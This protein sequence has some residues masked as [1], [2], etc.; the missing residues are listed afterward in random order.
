MMSKSPDGPTGED[1]NP[2]RESALH[3]YRG[4]VFDCD[5][6]LLNSN[7]VKTRAF[8][9][10][11]R[12][13]GEA[14]ATTLVD[15]HT[16]HGGIS[17]YQKFD[18]FFRHIL[19]Y[20]QVP[21]QEMAKILSRFA[22]A[23]RAGMASCEEAPGL[24]DFLSLLPQGCPR[25][26]ISGGDQE[27]LRGIFKARGLDVYFDAILGSPVD[28]DTHLGNILTEGRIDLPAVFFGDAW[29]DFQVA[30]RHGLDFIFLSGWSELDAWQS[31]FAGQPVQIYQDMAELRRALWP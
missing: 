28:K 23:V 2:G 18:Y 31:R 22:G 1:V 20:E 27:E 16:A 7:P 24:R 4:F 30:S 29:Y 26:V 9:E 10:A 6:V 17:R 21:D 3:T 25:V 11:A 13:W 8:F 14:A 19:G 12:P 5:G 15:Y